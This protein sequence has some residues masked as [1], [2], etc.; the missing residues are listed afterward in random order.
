MKETANPRDRL[1]FPPILSH[2]PRRVVTLRL[3]LVVLAGLALPGLQAADAPASPE[4]R[5]LFVKN[6]APCHGE[7]GRARSPAARKLG[8]KDLTQH[9]LTDDQIRTQILE[10]VQTKGSSAKMPAFKDKFSQE[11]IAGLIAIVKRFRP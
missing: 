4:I 3:L 1:K 5:K 2:I 10:G 11:E 9:K 7:D 8:V 6:C